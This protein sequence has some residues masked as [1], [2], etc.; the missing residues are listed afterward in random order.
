MYCGSICVTIENYVTAPKNV[1]HIEV[2]LNMAISIS[3][4][5]LL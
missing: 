4:T 5:L 1:E 2:T 3:L